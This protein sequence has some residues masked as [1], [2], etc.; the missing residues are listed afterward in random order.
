MHKAYAVTGGICVSAAALIEGT[1]VNEVAGAQARRTGTV[2]IGHPSGVS[3]F[4]VEVVKK[5]SGEIELTKSAVVGTARRIM[6][7]FVYVPLRV[8]RPIRSE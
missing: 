2:R 1:V 5:S 8:L 6:D 3:S 7:G 4:A